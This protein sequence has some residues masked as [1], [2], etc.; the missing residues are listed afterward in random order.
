MLE[1]L[2]SPNVWI[3]ELRSTVAQFVHY[4]L[5]WQGSLSCLGA[6]FQF[7]QLGWGERGPWWPTAWWELR[8]HRG[9]SPSLAADMGDRLAPLVPATNALGPCGFAACPAGAYAIA[10]SVPPLAEIEAVADRRELRRSGLQ[11]SGPQ[12]VIVS[13]HGT[14]EVLDQTV[15]PESWFGG[16][17]QWLLTRARRF[18]FPV[19]INEGEM[20]A[21][22]A[23]LAVCCRGGLE[24][25]TTILDLCD[26][27]V[28]CGIWMRG[29][30]SAFGPNR[31]ARRRS[32]L[33]AAFHVRCLLPWLS[34]RF[35]PADAG[36]RVDANGSLPIPK[37]FFVCA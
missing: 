6:I 20:K 4:G 24:E 37:P 29:R 18:R 33:E 27:Q 5:L 13:A 15:V 32:A 25:R 14:I 23:A 21:A 9:L 3:P 17:C 12:P 7:M 28:S 1:L 2:G 30:S 22:I 11:D 35:Q 36:T 16:A 34:T 10:A 26:S 8:T 31:E 19:H